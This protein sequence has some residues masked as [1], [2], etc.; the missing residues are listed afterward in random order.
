MKDVVV[1]DSKGNVV[2]KDIDVI[3][4]DAEMAQKEGYDYFML[5]EIHE[6]DSAIRDTLF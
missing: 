1:K 6:Q 2:D 4:W 5:K 3:D